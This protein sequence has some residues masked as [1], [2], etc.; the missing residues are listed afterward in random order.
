MNSAKGNTSNISSGN[1]ASDLIALLLLTLL[2]GI[3]FSPV[4]FDDKVFF[5]RDVVKYTFPEKYIIASFLKNGSLPFWNPAIF[6]GTPFLSLLN[7][8]PTYPLNFL[9]MGEDFI[10]A[11][12]QFMIVNYL[13]LIYSV[14]ALTR[15]W[16]ITPPGALASAIIAAFGGYFLSVFSLGNHFLSAIWTPL[17]LLYFQKFLLNGKTRYFILAVIF[18]TFQTLGGSAENCILSTLVLYSTSIFLVGD[19]ALIKGWLRRTFAV[20]GLV[21]FALGL[22]AFQLLPTY[23]LVQYSVRDWGLSFEANTM[24]SMDPQAL[25]S[26]FFPY[27]LAGFM[28]RTYGNLDY[29][30]NIPFFPSVFMGVIPIFFLCTGA[31]LFK[32]KEIKFWTVVFFVGIF[33]ALG[34][35]NPLYFYLFKW[36]P[37]LDMFRYPQKFFFLSAFSLVFITAFWLKAFT[38]SVEEGRYKFKPMLLLSLV[39][40]MALVWISIWVHWRHAAMTFLFIVA[41]VFLCRLFYQSSLT[42][43]QFKWSVMVIILVDLVISNHMV[44]PLIDRDFYAKEPE[45]ANSVGKY[46]SG[47][48]IYSGPVNTKTIPDRSVFPTAP[49]HLLSHIFEKE[50]LFPKLGTYYGFEYADGSLGV[51]LKDNWLWINM[52]NKFSPEKRL[53][54]LERSN[55]KYWI[56]TENEAAKNAS[57]SPIILRKVKVLDGVL[58]RAFIVNKVRRDHEAYQNYFNEDIDPLEEALVYEPVKLQEQENFEGTVKEISYGLNKVTVHSQQNG[59]GVLVL[60]DSY[61]PGWEVQV[62]GKKEKLMRANYFYRGVKL[63]PGKHTVEFNYE[64]VGFRAGLT[65]SSVTLLMLFLCSIGSLFIKRKT[66]VLEG[67]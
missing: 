1:Y 41:L 11:F 22:S 18:L 51:E 29:I 6:S 37:M 60:L 14:Y 66:T 48:R 5:F 42:A 24:W 36:L 3:F 67:S 46:E 49:N 62:D 26:L 13:I 20:G 2:A 65:I 16:G 8:S 21:F 56:T 15:F 54:M 44:I 57:G 43:M 59:E 40:S 39:I 27:D 28:G 47:F 33:F 55:V 32:T 4:L 9:L 53:R 63:R 45:L 50:R 19:R 58:P 35:Y 52:F 12:H 34:Q 64:P 31:I 17:I 10:F 30:K 38:A 23:A 7:P 25:I 61:F